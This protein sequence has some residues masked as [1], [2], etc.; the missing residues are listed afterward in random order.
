MRNHLINADRISIVTYKGKV[1]ALDTPKNQL[2]KLV[3][4]LLN[5]DRISVI[6]NKVQATAL[7]TKEGYIINQLFP[8]TSIGDKSVGK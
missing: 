5:A 7:D 6:S 2:S 1:T 8:H 3:T 4:N